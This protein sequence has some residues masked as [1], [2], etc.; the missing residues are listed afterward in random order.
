M[1]KIGI[2]LATLIFPVY[3][4]LGV[5]NDDKTDSV[6][7]GFEDIKNSYSTELMVQELRIIDREIHRLKPFVAFPENQLR[8][9]LLLASHDQALSSD[10][11]SAI[12]LDWTKLTL[13]ENV[14]WK[15]WVQG[16]AIS[17]I[18]TA[19]A[20]LDAYGWSKNLA[21]SL[22]NQITAKDLYLMSLFVDEHR[23]Q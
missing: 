10:S 15:D 23:K 16:I 9:L 4:G 8:A 17:R 18:A 11:N 5:F 7:L 12:Q 6:P 20:Q 19:D 21:E 22:N 14:G 2:Y 13:D 3:L 1:V